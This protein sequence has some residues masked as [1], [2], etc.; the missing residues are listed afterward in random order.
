[1]GDAGFGG[2][3]IAVAGAGVGAVPACMAMELSREVRLACS[4]RTAAV[5]AQRAVAAT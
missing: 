2:E 3:A 1:M 5:Q 4:S